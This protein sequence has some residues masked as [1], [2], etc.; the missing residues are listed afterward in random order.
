MKRSILFFM[1]I[2][3][4]AMLHAQTIGVQ[5]YTF[6]NQ[7]AK[8]VKGTVE[9][10][11]KM[12]ISE[13][14][15]GGSYGMPAND[16]KKLLDDNNIK[17]VSVGGDFEQLQKNPQQ[18]IAEAKFYGS[19][20]VVCFWIPH[21]DSLGFNLDD[22]NKAV[23]VFNAAGKLFKENGLDFCYH[24]HGYEFVPY[25]QSN[26]YDLM[27]Q[28]LDPK[29]VNFEMDVYWMK[30]PGQDPVQLLKQ[31]PGRYKLLHLKDRRIG[32]PNSMN[33]QADVETN[34]VLGSGDVGIAAIMQA[35]K[36]A[37]I[38]HYFIE[39]ESSR[40]VEQ[41]PQSLAYLKMLK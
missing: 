12:G 18:I 24:A 15:G 26:L 17:V 21:S 39:D 30:Q 1:T 25:G 5:L 19:K 23:A 20:Y 31:Y 28:T 11:H 27:M 13:V 41:V 34:V 40:S 9:M 16:F 38:K 6:R 3:L 2:V 14:E 37:G 10:I 8:D 35:A 36:D 7:F 32:S 4:N 33:G 29:Y 22:A